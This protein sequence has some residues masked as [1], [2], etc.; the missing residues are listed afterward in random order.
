MLLLHHY[1][2][3]FGKEQIKG[4]GQ[5]GLEMIAV[6]IKAVFLCCVLTTG[7]GSRNRSIPGRQG[8]SKRRLKVPRHRKESL[9][10]PSNW[11]KQERE[12]VG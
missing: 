10:P 12:F 11:P 2:V 6:F 4:I 9:Q 5:D 7:K 8:I 1:L 3:T